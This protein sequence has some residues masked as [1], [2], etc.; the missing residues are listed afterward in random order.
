MN[1]DQPAQPPG[2]RI[3]YQRM[4]IRI[5]NKFQAKSFVEYRGSLNLICGIFCGVVSLLFDWV[6][7][8]CETVIDNLT[9]VQVS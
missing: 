3:A 4:I 2:G 1:F 7:D 9:V 5:A 8:R 6:L